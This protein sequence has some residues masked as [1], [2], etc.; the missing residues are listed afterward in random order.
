M[1][2]DYFISFTEEA[3]RVN[4]MS[5]YDSSM[6]E[7][8]TVCKVYID[9]SIIELKYRSKSVTITDVDGCDLTEVEDVL[10]LIKEY[11]DDY[12]EDMS[13]FNFHRLTDNGGD[14]TYI[15]ESRYHTD[16]HEEDYDS[17][18]YK[19][20]VNQGSRLREEDN[21][22]SLKMTVMTM[23]DELEHRISAIEDAVLKLQNTVELQKN[24]VQTQQTDDETLT[25]LSNKLTNYTDERVRDLKGDI[26]QISQVLKSVVL[27][28]KLLR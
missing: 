25:V 20:I 19:D 18:D 9:R 15:T 7:Y 4:D 1:Q 28:D 24:V 12:P 14:T 3:T 22:A 27:V 26:N 11:C 8:V 23:K 6:S 2:G 5:V 13:V 17:K 10:G 16:D 21:Y